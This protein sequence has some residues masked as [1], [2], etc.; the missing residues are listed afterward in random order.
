MEEITPLATSTGSL[1]AP[2][3]VYQPKSKSKLKI[4]TELKVK[5]VTLIHLFLMF[6]LSD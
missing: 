4:L 3:E 6:S 2:E 1:L 5:P